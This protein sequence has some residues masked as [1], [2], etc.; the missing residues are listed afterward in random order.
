MNT[1][2]WPLKKS[3]EKSKGP[4]WKREN[5]LEVESSTFDVFD[6]Q[7]GIRAIHEGRNSEFTIVGCF[8]PGG[9]MSENCDERGSS[10]ILEH[11]LFRV[12]NKI[13]QN[14]IFQLKRKLFFSNKKM[15]SIS[16]SQLKL[17]KTEQNDLIKFEEKMGIIGGKLGALAMRDGFVYYGIAP[18]NQADKI[19]EILSDVTFNRVLC[20]IYFSCFIISCN[21][22]FSLFSLFDSDLYIMLTVEFDYF[23]IFF[24]IFVC[25]LVFFFNFRRERFITSEMLDISTPE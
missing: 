23:L 6:L 17:Q 16:H 14:I 25:L 8:V 12:I 21:L 22:R 10:L 1:K 7:N 4:Y 3:K 5:P 20:K 2:I 24:C 13:V 9:S 19:V 18:N 15:F 11:M